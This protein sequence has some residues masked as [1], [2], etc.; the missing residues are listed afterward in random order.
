MNSELATFGVAIDDSDTVAL[1]AIFG[2]VAAAAMDTLDSRREESNDC[3]RRRIF[4]ATTICKRASE[5]TVMSSKPPHITAPGILF[6]Y[7]GRKFS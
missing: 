4:S 5:A 1:F 3:D 2:V 6:A 7:S